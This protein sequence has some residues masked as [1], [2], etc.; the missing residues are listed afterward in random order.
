MAVFWKEIYC[1]ESIYSMYKDK[2]Q[3]CS[4]NPVYLHNDTSDMEMNIN[5]SANLSSIFSYV[6]VYIFC[7][8]FV[9]S[10]RV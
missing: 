2:L 9:K 6:Y 5:I 7:Y 3:N 1:T 10:A 4:C 8:M